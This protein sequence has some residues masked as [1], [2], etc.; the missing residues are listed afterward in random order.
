MK[1]KILGVI[2]LLV[3]MM[4]ASCSISHEETPQK[5]QKQKAMDEATR[6][7]SSPC[8]QASD[9]E[10]A[11]QVEIT[12]AFPLYIEGINEISYYECKATING[13]NA[14]Y[15]L[16][17]VND[18]DFDFPEYSTDGVTMTEKIVGANSRAV[19]A[20]I[21]RYNAFEYLA[22]NNSRGSENII[23]EL[24]FSGTGNVNDSKTMNMEEIS[25]KRSFTKSMVALNKTVLPITQEELIQEK[26][27]VNN[28]RAYNK[29]TSDELNHT[30]RSGWHLPKW[31]QEVILDGSNKEYVGCTPLAVTMV[32]AYWKQFKGKSK[33]FDGNSLT[34]KSSMSNSGDSVVIDAVTEIRN[35]LGTYAGSRVYDTNG[36]FTG[37]SGRTETGRRLETLADNYGDDR[38][39]S[40]DIDVDYG[41][42]W[43]K[44]KKAYDR[45]KKDQ[46][47]WMSIDTSGGRASDHSV[48]VEGVKFKERVRGRRNKRYYNREM[49]Y[50]MN[51]GWGDTRK[52][53]KTYD[54][55][56][57]S[58]ETETSGV[59]HIWD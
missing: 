16:V 32:Y 12:E 9:S 29:W 41:G 30:F 26:E 55:F 5:D 39:Y 42:D 19:S 15:I 51:Y 4:F 40:Y 49:H 17:N 14:G 58:S 45:I 52:W 27:E 56:D 22:I 25:I 23:A 11:S 28:S 10:W 57:N 3:V 37:Y 54:R 24:G 6:Y 8:V 13:E 48:A 36:N 1:K 34:Y 53:V 20:K 21:Y 35:D 7:L 47:L 38:G 59:Y 46:P 33:L 44:G 18:T 50:L 2:S 31:T 43:S